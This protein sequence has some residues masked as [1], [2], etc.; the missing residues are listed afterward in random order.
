MQRMF[1]FRIYV[2]AWLGLVLLAAGCAGQRGGE[3]AVLLNDTFTL[4]YG[5]TAVLPAEDLRLTFDDVLEDS[6]CPTQVSCFWTGQ[7]RI[8]ITA[9]QG[10]AE[11]VRLEFNTNP[12][13]GQTV[14]S[15]PVGAYQVDVQSLDPY[16][17]D[18]DK[19]PKAGEY[20]VTLQVT[21]P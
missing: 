8:A 2:F 13:P 14:L 5:E 16:P 9:Q 6:R 12:A 11:P 19:L 18:P 17:Q 21:K 7:A 10:D 3:T 15:L 1:A 4:G 20:R